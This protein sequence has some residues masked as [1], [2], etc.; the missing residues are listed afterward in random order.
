M[1]HADNLRQQ[2][3]FS[4]A[5][6]FNLEQSTFFLIDSQGYL[7]DPI[8]L[9]VESRA[10]DSYVTHFQNKDIFHPRNLPR[11]KY[12]QNPVMYITDVM[13]LKDFER[14]EYYNDFLKA[15][16]VYH[17]TIVSLTGKGRLLGGIG[18]YKPKNEKFDQDT[19]S[20]LELLTRFL[21]GQLSLHLA[22][23][24][25]LEGQHLYHFCMKEN[26]AGIILFDEDFSVLFSNMAAREMVAALLHKRLD[27]DKFIKDIVSLTG[28]FSSPSRICSLNLYSPSLKKFAIRVKQAENSLGS[29]RKTFLMELMPEGFS[30]HGDAW[31]DMNIKEK[32][33]LTDRELQVLGMIMQG[34]TNIETAESLFI[35]PNTV[36]SHLRSILKKTG[37]CNRIKLYQKVSGAI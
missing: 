14:T 7:F 6:L 15:Q 31:L 17:E 25:A 20:H 2:V 29:D 4:L 8:A 33:D 26:P 1:A 3:L 18:L 28:V 37:A 27:L 36:K 11:K 23:Q 10:I 21:A 35:S 19:R 32:Y 13:S 34:L 9:N 24:R 16:G 5:E 12:L 30:S 22:L